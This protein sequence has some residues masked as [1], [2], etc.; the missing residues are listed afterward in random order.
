MLSIQE[1]RDPLGMG[2]V[3]QKYTSHPKEAGGGKSYSQEGMPV[4]TMGGRTKREEL[5]EKVFR[6]GW[7]Q[8]TESLQ[9]YCDRMMPHSI[10]G[11]I[12]F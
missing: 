7:R 8:P 3:V 6:P 12:F 2:A 4:G 10:S 5:Q 1:E 9:E 11:L